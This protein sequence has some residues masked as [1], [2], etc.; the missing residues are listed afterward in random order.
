MFPES[1]M[2]PQ[3]SSKSDYSGYDCQDKAVFKLG[4][5]MDLGLSK[6]GNRY[7]S[8][9]NTTSKYTRRL[10]QCF[11]DPTM[12]VFMKRPESFSNITISRLDNVE[13]LLPEGEEARISFYD[14]SSGT[15][16][17]Y[18]GNSAI[19]RTSDPDKVT[20]SVTSYNKIPYIDYG[21]SR[22]EYIQNEEISGIRSYLAKTIKV[23]NHVTDSKTS[24][25]VVFKNGVI[26]LKA[27]EVEFNAGTSINVGAELSVDTF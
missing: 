7:G 14:E 2:N 22:I 25:D 17:S 24:G 27:K 19:F 1:P 26:N 21:G 10:F 3:F 12:H 16:R 5:V 15:V 4:Q 20:V 9:T 18:I 11:G 23:G 13:V 8:S 6:I